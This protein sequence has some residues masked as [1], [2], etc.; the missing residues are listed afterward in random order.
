LI[1][2]EGGITFNMNLGL[3]EEFENLYK[4]RIMIKI[5]RYDTAEYIEP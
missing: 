2:D 1:V 4:G 5:S 3:K